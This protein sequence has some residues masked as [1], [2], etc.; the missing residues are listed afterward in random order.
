MEI[1]LL[2]G[3]EIAFEMMI[4][5]YSVRNKENPATLRNIFRLEGSGMKIAVQHSKLDPFSH[6]L[7]Y[8]GKLSDLNDGVENFDMAHSR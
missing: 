1:N 8:E 4:W 3:D 6:F 2:L 5:N 7:I